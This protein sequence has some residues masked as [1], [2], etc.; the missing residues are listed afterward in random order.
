MVRLSFI[1]AV[2]V[3]ALSAC[4]TG[5][6]AITITAKNAGDTIELQTGEIMD[7]TLEGNP[8]T[9]YQ[10][11]PEIPLIGMLE[12]VGEAEF[13]PDS[14]ATGSGGKVTLTFKAIAP[15]EGTLRL[16]YRRP[17]EQEMEP[18]EAFEVKVVVRPSRP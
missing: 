11:E 12:Q 1:C 16:I 5:D 9:G 13:V 10:W 3:F 6:S 4:N 17:W 7:I 14:Q 8:T 2:L 18:L 15:G